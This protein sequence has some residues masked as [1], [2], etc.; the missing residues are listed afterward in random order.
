MPL[1]YLIPA[2]LHEDSLAPLPPYILEAVKNCRVLFVENERTTRRYL[3]KLDKNLVI[4]HFEWC[5]MHKNDDS[6]IQLFET[7][8]KEEGNIGIISEAGCPG[9]ADPG[10]RLIEAA[11]KAGAVV[12]PLSGP[13]SVFMALMASGLNGQQFCFHGYLPIDHAQRIRRLKQLE[14]QSLRHGITQIFIE[15]PYRNQQL[16][17]TLLKQCQPHTRLCVAVNITADDEWILTATI[18]AWKKIKADLHK[19]P[20]IFLLGK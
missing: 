6:Y 20:A 8:L 7:K 15:T 2:P 5:V 10:Q 3:K 13:S 16:L 17:E 18:Q 1:V 19:R 12:K 14:E 4:D 11:H 9:I